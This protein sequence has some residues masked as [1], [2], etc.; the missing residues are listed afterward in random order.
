MNFIVIDCKSDSPSMYNNIKTVIDI[1]SGVNYILTGNGG[2][3]PRYNA[4][5]TLMIT[6]LHEVKRYVSTINE[7]Q[8][9]YI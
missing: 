9:K 2:I 1:H 3:C 8:V 5:G 7:N 6:P 4:D